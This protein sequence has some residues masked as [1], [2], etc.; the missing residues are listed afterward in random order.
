MTQVSKALSNTPTWDMK[1]WQDESP[2][3]VGF[4]DRWIT[5]QGDNWPK[6]F[7]RRT[8]PK[9]PLTPMAADLVGALDLTPGTPLRIL[10]IG[11]GPLSYVG[12]DHPDHQIDLTVVDPLAESYNA[13]LDQAGIKDV[14]RP[15]PG[16]FETALQDFGEN[17]FDLVWCFNSLDHS[18]DPLLGLY[19]L[20]SVCRV[21]GGLILSFCPNEAE[22]GKYKGLHQWNLDMQGD[23]GVVL[24]QMGKKVV[25]QGLIRQQKVVRRIVANPTGVSKD[26]VTF[27]IKKIAAVNLS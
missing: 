4:W 21:G 2:A 3:E 1:S 14:P 22:K 10:D 20:L 13:L 17:S 5:T 25:L 23:Q 18:I 7:Q 9:A 27:F 24:T 15:Q 6:D 19:N 8:D 12:Y 11:A 16:Y 26:R